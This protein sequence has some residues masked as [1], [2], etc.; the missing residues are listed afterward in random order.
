MIRNIR[1]KGMSIKSIAKEL[2]ISRNSVRKYLRS[3]PKNRQNRKRGS[4]LD[5]YRD[6]IRELINKHNL[7]S[8]KIL[9]EIRKLSYDRGYTILKYYCR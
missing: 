6:R 8:V 2:S 5:P 3:E 4:K 1:E 9:E 7:S